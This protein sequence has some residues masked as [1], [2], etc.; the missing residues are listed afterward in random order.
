[1][2]KFTKFLRRAFGGASYE[3]IKALLIAEAK[4]TMER[5]LTPAIEDRLVLAGLPRAQAKG[6]A[7]AIIETVIEALKR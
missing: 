6:L 3:R 2:S 5:E 1:M 4:L 7:L